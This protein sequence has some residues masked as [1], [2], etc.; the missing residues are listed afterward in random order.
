MA[1]SKKGDPKITMRTVKAPVNKITASLRDQ[2]FTRLSSLKKDEA[3][4]IGGVP[5]KR[6]AYIRS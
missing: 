1:V 6:Q 2:I 4:E 5:K 3:L